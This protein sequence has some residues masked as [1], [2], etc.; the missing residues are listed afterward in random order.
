MIAPVAVGLALVAIA[1]YGLSASRNLV[2]ILISMEI[3]TVGV[4]LTLA[5]VF[6]VAPSPALW[7]LILLVS[8]A[9]SEVAV[10]SA[11]IYRA[12]ALTKS[13]DVQDLKAGREP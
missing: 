13:T 8:M 6:A 9:A 11:L 1:L 12:Y 10:L 3:A 2:R 5:P 7:S 4:I